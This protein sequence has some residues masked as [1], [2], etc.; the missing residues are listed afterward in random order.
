MMYC[1]KC[2]TTNDDQAAF[3]RQCGTNLKPVGGA[4]PT[5]VPAAVIYAGFWKRFAAFIIDAIVLGI[6]G[7]IIRVFFRFAFLGNSRVGVIILLTSP[8][9]IVIGPCV[10]P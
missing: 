5:I 10:T 1:P 9:S 7:S 2:G 4:A 8:I 3:C 6:V